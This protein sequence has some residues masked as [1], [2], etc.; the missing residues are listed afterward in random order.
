M[1]FRLVLLPALQKRVTWT[2]SCLSALHQRHARH[3]RHAFLFSC[4]RPSCLSSHSPLPRCGPALEENQRRWKDD[5][6]NLEWAVLLHGDSA[7][8]RLSSVLGE[9]RDIHLTAVIRLSLGG[10]LVVFLQ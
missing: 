2:S 7:V 5:G 1:T 8:C 4:A 3:A 6:R 9:T 10:M